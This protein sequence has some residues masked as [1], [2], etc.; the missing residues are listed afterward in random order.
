MLCRHKIAL[1]DGTSGPTRLLITREEIKESAHAN[2]LLE[3][4][5][6]QAEH[7]L[8]LA[9]EQREELHQKASVE[10]WQRANSQLKRWE[11]RH[12]M[13]SDNIEQYAT[14]I[15]NQALLCLL[16]D[17]AP[18]QRVS[19]LIKQLM[20]AQM[21]AVKATLLCHP[22]ERE[23]VER[24][25]ARHGATPWIVRT[26]ELV[27]PQTLVLETDEGDFRIDWLSMRDILL[28]PKVGKH[29]E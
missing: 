1:H 25:L 21:P 9:A 4:A 3:R 24:C 14:S 26:E 12:Q 8:Q 16:D 19:A 13:L 6:V 10:F 2:Q 18:A 27:K 11:S 28:A 7:L 23:T 5:K 22:L 17:V 15:A 29:S 20:A